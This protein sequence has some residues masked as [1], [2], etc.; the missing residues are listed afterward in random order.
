MGVLNGP[1]LDG[2][3][4]WM[5]VQDPDLGECWKAADPRRTLPPSQ[6]DKTIRDAQPH[7]RFRQPSDLVCFSD[8]RLLRF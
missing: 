8:C 4:T 1:V 2:D 3:A 5:K 7:S 6:L